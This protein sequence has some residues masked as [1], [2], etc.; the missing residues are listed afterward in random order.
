MTSEVYWVR[1]I[2]PLKLAIMPRPRGGEW[3][4][5]EVAGW[6][7]S[8]ITNVVSLLHRYEIEELSISGEEAL[9]K[10]IGIEYRSFPIQDRGTPVGSSDF[11]ALVDDLTLLVQNGGGVA[12]HCRAGI[13]RS[14]LTAACV[15]LKLGIAAPDAFPMLSRARGLAVPDTPSQVEWFQSVATRHARAL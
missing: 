1:D 15:L 10:S 13:G 9:C 3:L 14:G 11:F 12:I 6:R 2:E 5:D 4:E 8:G 7:Q